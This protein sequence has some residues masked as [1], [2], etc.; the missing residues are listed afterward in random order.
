MTPVTIQLNAIARRGRE[1]KRME[2][3]LL[4]R[5]RNGRPGDEIGLSRQVA[6]ATTQ[7]VAR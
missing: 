6:V 3:C 7:P 4:N 5:S 1:G 2:R